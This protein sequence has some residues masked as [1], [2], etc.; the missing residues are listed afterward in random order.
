MECSEW[1]PLLGGACDSVLGMGV[2]Q[3]VIVGSSPDTTRG[4]FWLIKGGICSFRDGIRCLPGDAD[5]MH[6]WTQPC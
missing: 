5:D 2:Q 1:T 4:I 3:V 6:A